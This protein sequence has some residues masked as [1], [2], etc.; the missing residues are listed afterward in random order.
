M[1]QRKRVSVQLTREAI[2]RMVYLLSIAESE[3]ELDLRLIDQLR[4]ARYLFG[5]VL[6]LEPVPI[7]AQGEPQ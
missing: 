2:E 7:P 1:S 6:V 5:D 4:K 3:T